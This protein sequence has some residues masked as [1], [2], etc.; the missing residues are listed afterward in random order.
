MLKDQT[1]YAVKEGGTWKVAEYTF[2]GLL[3][4]QGN[5]PA[6][7]KEPAATQAPK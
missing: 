3:T 5:P 2:C 6:A 7:C 1:G 4:L